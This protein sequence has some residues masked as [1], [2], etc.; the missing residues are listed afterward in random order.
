MGNLLITLLSTVFKDADGK[1]ILWRLL[2]TVIICIGAF[3]WYARTELFNLY[4]DTRYEAYLEVQA[5][6]RE[7]KF[8]K[9]VQEQLQI[10]HIS[11]GAEFSGVTEF[12]PKNRNFFFDLIEFEGKLPDELNP[13]N[14]G[15]YPI[16]KTSEEY[17]KHSNGEYYVSDTT[18]RLPTRSQLEHKHVFSCP[19]FNLDN[20]YSGSIFMMW[21]KDQVRLPD[22]RLNLICSSAS[23]TL[24]RTK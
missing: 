4:R 17:I 2:A 5:N 13:N 16:D 11:S 12:R 6:E 19:Y 23:R 7:N 14:L 9:T 20:V 8:L 24:G 10:V 18:F 22:D 21:D 1:L 15:G 3:F